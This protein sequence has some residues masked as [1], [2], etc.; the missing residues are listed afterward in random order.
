MFFKQHLKFAKTTSFSQIK[1]HILCI[2]CIFYHSKAVFLHAVF[3]I[4]DKL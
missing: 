3:T 2:Y 4:N 1:Y